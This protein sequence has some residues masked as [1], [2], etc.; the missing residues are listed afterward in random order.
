[1]LVSAS[2]KVDH[3][4]RWFNDSMY[5][6]KS[7]R[8]PFFV[9][10]FTQVLSFSEDTNDVAFAAYNSE[11]DLIIIAGEA[12]EGEDHDETIIHHLLH[13]YSHALG[14]MDEDIAN[15]FADEIYAKYLESRTYK[16]FVEKLRK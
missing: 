14:N 10:P 6:N 9:I 3:F 5:C 12:P 4:I 16:E 13:E 15:S 11:C 1:M 2:A 8:V 7:R